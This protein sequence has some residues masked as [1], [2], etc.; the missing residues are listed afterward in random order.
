MLTVIQINPIFWHK[1]PRCN[2]VR[3]LP[4]RQILK[5]DIHVPVCWHATFSIAHKLWKHPMCAE[6]PY[7]CPIAPR[8]V[9]C[10]QNFIKIYLV[11]LSWAHMGVHFVQFTWLNGQASQMNENVQCY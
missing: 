9:K 1:K 7:A 5:Q 3:P 10:H 2:A 11:Q 4:C 6:T 8:P